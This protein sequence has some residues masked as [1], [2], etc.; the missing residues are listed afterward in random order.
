MDFSTITDGHTDGFIPIGISQRVAKKK[1]GIL[2]QLLMSMPTCLPMNFATITDVCA[3][4]PKRT[5]VD[6]TN[7]RGKKKYAHVLVHNFQWIY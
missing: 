7:R 4:F 3:H 2:P 1:Y 5:R 6:V